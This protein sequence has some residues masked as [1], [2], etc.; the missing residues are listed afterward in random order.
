MFSAAN[1]AHFSLTIDDLQHDL[2]VLSF[3]GTEAISTPFAFDVALVSERADLE[4]E[5]LLHKQ[6]FLAFN[7]Q[8]A[9]IH[10]QV[11]RVSQGDAGK[12]LTRYNLRLVPQLAYLGLRRNH[13]IFQQRTL[14]QIIAQV[15]E[16]HG[17]LSDAY[18]LH[19][20]KTSTPREYCVQ[21]GESDLHFLQRLCFEE[22][23]SY[24]FRHSR[25]GHTVV[26]SDHQ[27]F[28]P[29]LGQPT[30]YQQDSGLV[31]DEPVISRFN[32]RVEAR[33]RRTFWRDYDFEK[34]SFVL[35]AE[36]Q[37]DTTYP[38]PNPED[39]TYPGGFLQ[40]EE[41]KQL[42]Q[43]ALERHRA[44]HRVAEGRSDQP[45]LVTGHLLELSGHPCQAWNDLWLLTEIQ[46]QGKQP[47]VLE[48]SM[49]AD[50]A[51]ADDGFSQGYRNHFTA[52]PWDVFYRPQ[53][54]YHKPRVLGSQTAR[55]TGPKGEE[56][57]CDAYGRVKVQFH[58]DREGQHNDQSSCWLRVASGWAGNGHGSV[59]IPR[60]G[61][62]VLV[63]F[64]EGDPDRPLVS[65]CL[66]NSLNPVPHALPA[67]KTRSVFRSRSTP[68]GGGYNEL[69]VEDRKGHELIYLRA[70]RDLEQK[71]ERESR[72]EVGGEYAARVKGNSITVLEAEEHYTVKA[73]RKVQL[74]ASEYLEVGASSHTRVG[75]T[76][77][78]EAG[79]EVH[80]KAGARMVLDA[81]VSLTLKAGGQHIVI[82][83]GGIFSSS[84]IQVGG[85]PVTGTAVALA[86]AEQVEALVAMALDS[87]QQALQRAA[88]KTAGVCAICQ[89]LAALKA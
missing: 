13:R 77:A 85:A 37:A 43:R 86:Q 38:E 51:A 64:L 55:V 57:Y 3:T 61:M 8:G 44:E 68:G 69:H 12:R 62:E 21:Y 52:T 7:A 66:P 59:S 65:G 79:Q 49:T 40:G 87:Q 27:T 89:K 22:G 60:V 47:Q 50:C 41:G 42:S 53:Q 30:P 20:E 33:T 1:H 74:K 58:W 2:Q 32:L 31:A 23:V 34:S 71:V 19:L 67:N 82:G 84:E 16:E 26:F 88:Q 36:R 45:S 70:Q 28:F 73:D 25:A 4:L 18:Q 72:L 24:T 35:E 29:K 5:T 80:L 10:G 48:E 17:I 15:L 46:H 83:A 76:L 54:A 81:G 9:G 11:Y 56:V 6:A 75:Q 63:V 14:A 39:Y 78:T